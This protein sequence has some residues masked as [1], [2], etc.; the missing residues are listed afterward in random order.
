MFGLMHGSA[1]FLKKA[2]TGY[3][4]VILLL[5]GAVVFAIHR[6]DRV[7]AVRAASFRSH[8]LE[9]TMVERLRWTNELIVS[10]GR[11]YLVAGAPDLLAPLEEAAARF[12]V[13]IDAMKA[14]DQAQ[15]TADPLLAAVERAANAFQRTQGELV[16]ARSSGQDPKIVSGLFERKLRPL[17]QETTEAL[18]QL[19][20]SKEARLDQAYEQAKRDRAR[21][22]AL[23][24]EMLAALVA[25][26]LGIAWYFTRVLSRAY[27]GEQEALETMRRAVAGRDQLMGMVAHDLRNPLSAIK[28]RAVV[29]RK[30]TDPEKTRA[31]MESI[32]AVAGRMEH[33]INSLLDAASIEAGR[34]TVEPAACDLDTLV[35]QCFEV[36]GVLAAG[37]S[38]R[39]E[40]SVEPPG[41]A[42]LA[43]RER[44]LQVLSNLL[45]NAIKFTPDGGRITLSAAPKGDTVRFA[46]ADSGPGI[47]PADLSHLF[48]RYWKHDKGGTK[49]TGLGLFIAKGIVEAHQ[50]RLWVESE[51]GRGTTFY[52]SLPSA[53]AAHDEIEVSPEVAAPADGGRHWGSH[54]ESGQH[55]LLGVGP[56]G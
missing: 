6:L 28:I 55:G 5:V 3:A 8:E 23:T 47:A 36:F 24:W 49:G 39:L 54:L 1:S 45:G 35:D 26:V 7:A 13:T 21:A 38:I 9:I 29:A 27:R 11:G 4:I 18:N 34:F 10:T 30:V 51:P 22:M 43:D 12:R 42:V 46:V 16:R 53:R 33:L 44:V 37:K 14:N 20:Q 48:D 31:H 50:G 40:K 15:G 17:R 32:A 56:K 2:M 25:L 41:V 19:V 52:F